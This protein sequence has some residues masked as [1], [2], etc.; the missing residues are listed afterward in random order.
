MTKYLKGLNSSILI[1]IALFISVLFSNRI[2]AQERVISTGVP[3]LLITPDA[4]A[5]GMG[6]QGVATSV[7]AFSQ[8]W[9]PSKYVFSESKSGFGVSYTPYLSKLVNDIF[10]ANITY[11]NKNTDRSAWAASL[12]YFS[13]G[14]IVLNDLVAGSIIQQGVER[15]NELTLD[16][17]YSLLLN[18]KFSMAV[19]ARF[20]RSDLKISS[21]IDAS[22]ANTLGVDI[23][24]FYK[25]DLFDFQNNKA[26]LRLGFNISNI[27]PR[28]KYDEGGQKNFIPTNL[29]IGSGLNVHLDSNNKISFNL[30]FNKLLVPSPI[31]VFDENT[32][33]ILSYQQPDI[34]FLSGIPESFNDAP[35][36]LSEELK[37]ITWGLGTE[38]NFQDSFALRG[39]YFNESLEKGSRRYFTLGA[40][41]SLNFASIDIS[42]LFSTSKVRNPLEN[43]LRFSITFDLDGSEDAQMDD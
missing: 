41:F 36:G 2:T 32:G 37:E 28:L 34:S 24:G 17:S 4:R 31:A 3:F 30:E 5:A 1:F 22:S 6:E 29:R 26:R 20:I 11:F 42:Y 43:T 18:T 15:P 21:D 33:E 23:A 8:Q 7:D 14:D 10:L 25:S 13:L 39:G 9:N 12:K 40:G 27:G 16:F 38:Y 19:A 35:D